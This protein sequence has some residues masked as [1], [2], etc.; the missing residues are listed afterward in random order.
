MDFDHEGMITKKGSVRIF[1]PPQYRWGPR[2]LSIRVK[3]SSKITL[4]VYGTFSE[5]SNRSVDT[6]EFINKTYHEET[7]HPA[8]EKIANFLGK[9]FKHSSIHLIQC[10]LNI[11]F[12]NCTI[13]VLKPFRV[14]IGNLNYSE[15]LFRDSISIELY[16]HEDSIT[17][18]GF[19][20]YFS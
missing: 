19:R 8:E 7:V 4:S 12:H 6:T 11:L 2:C 20:K 5:N 17:Q 1:S 15:E 13:L 16:N 3:T 9:G 18:F 10:F 14:N